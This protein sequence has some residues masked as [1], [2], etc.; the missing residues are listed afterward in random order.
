AAR[1]AAGLVR[2]ARA[3]ARSARAFGL[4]LR[5]TGHRDGRRPRGAGALEGQRAQ[6]A[7]RGRRRRV[8]RTGG[9][10][11]DHR[12]GARV[13]GV[14][15]RGEGEHAAGARGDGPPGRRA[16]GDGD[17]VLLSARPADRQPRVA[18]RHPARAEANV[19]AGGAVRQGGTPRLTAVTGLAPAEFAGNSADTLRPVSEGVK[20]PLVVI[21]GP[22]GVGKTAVAAALARRGGVGG[23]SAGSGP[24]CWGVGG[25]EGE[26][27]ARGRG[28]GG[29][30]LL[31]G[32]EPV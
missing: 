19:V 10:R 8:R 2:L 15:G 20:V 16:V 5:R 29:C 13:R 24:G 6:A 32:G 9:E 21:A 25:G 11:A 1:A 26:T 4:R 22:T 31:V 27:G 18:A 3:L 7:R 12:P 30:P 17:A 23:G 14:P 28:G